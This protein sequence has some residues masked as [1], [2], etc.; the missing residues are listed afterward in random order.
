L[1]LPEAFGES[2]IFL[3]PG[4]VF[5]DL[6][7]LLGYYG[8]PLLIVSLTLAQLVLGG[9]IAVGLARGGRSGSA[10]RVILASLITAVGLWAL[11]VAIALPALAPTYFRGPAGVATAALLVELVSYGAVMGWLM[12]RQDLATPLVGAGRRRLLVVALVGLGVVSVAGGLVKL[13]AELGRGTPASARSYGRLSPEVTPNAEFY[14]VSKNV[15]DPTVKVEEWRLSVGGLVEHPYQLT[16]DELRSLPAVEQY[17]TLECISNE[18]GGNL[19]SNALWRGVRLSLLLEKAGLKEGVVDIVLRAVDDYSDSIPLDKALH[20]GTL[21][22]WEMNGEPLPQRHGFPARLVVP[23]IYGMK[24]V[25][26]LTSIEAVNQDYRGF[27]ERQGWDD[28]AAVKTMSRIDLPEM[29]ATLS[30]GRVMVGG[31][32]FAGDRSVVAV[33]VSF[34]D[35]K[36]WQ[37][38][39]LRPALGPYSWVL[40][41]AEGEL[42]R[43]GGRMI[44]VRAQDGTGQWQVSEF[45]DPYPSGATGLHGV[46]VLVVEG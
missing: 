13:L 17:T 19:I 41:T 26:W 43:T 4:Q 23:G 10:D 22:V 34:D 33:E 39:Q 29:G 30:L 21:V 2:L 44:R 1:T 8:K 11:L 15:V 20:P 37:T 36:T 45:N 6:L 16:Y 18:V 27:W 42:A 32:A 14:L 7:D 25:K 24:N 31:I 28:V 12:G 9:L 35:G 3:L 46:Y 5:S 38:A 40:W